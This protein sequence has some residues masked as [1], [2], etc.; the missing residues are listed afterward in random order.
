VLVGII[1][2]K[3][4]EEKVPATCDSS[5]DPFLPYPNPFKDQFQVK[6]VLEQANTLLF[7]LY[8]NN[9][10]LLHAESQDLLA[11]EY[12]ILLSERVAYLP[13]G[14]YY[15]RISDGEKELAVRKVVRVE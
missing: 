12:S 4:D 13:A 5:T 15:L 7:H 14:T 3:K 8:D 1:C 2:A 9:G 11:G 6:V 10:Q